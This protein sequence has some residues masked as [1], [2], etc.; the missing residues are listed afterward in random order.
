ME[1]GVLPGDPSAYDQQAPGVADFVRRTLELY[2]EEQSGSSTEDQSSSSSSTVGSSTEE[3]SSSK[4]FTE[5]GWVK[6]PFVPSSSSAFAVMK[7]QAF[8]VRR[9]AE[10]YNY[11]G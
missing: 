2:A 5:Q 4:P 1:T 11:V 6:D 9:L 3:Q 10:K 8:L 7:Q